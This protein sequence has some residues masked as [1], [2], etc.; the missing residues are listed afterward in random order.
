MKQSLADIVKNCPAG[1]VTVRD[2]Q[3]GRTHYANPKNGE[4][5]NYTSCFGWQVVNLPKVDP[6]PATPATDEAPAAE[7]A[8]KT[9]RRGRKTTKKAE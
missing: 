8:T 2:P 4:L 7:P 6:Q 3:T 9:T 1:R 5:G